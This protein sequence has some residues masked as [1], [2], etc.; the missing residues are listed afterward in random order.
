MTLSAENSAPCWKRIL[1]D[2][3]LAELAQQAAHLDEAFRRAG[4]IGAGGQ[5]P[6]SMNIRA[7][8]ASRKMMAKMACTTAAVTRWPRLSTSPETAM[9]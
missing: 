8:M 2:H 3:P 4:L 7:K 6:S 5:I 1:V 9:P